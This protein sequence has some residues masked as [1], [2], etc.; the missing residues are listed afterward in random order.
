MVFILI[1]LQFSIN[2]FPF[3]IIIIFFA[4][5]FSRNIFHSVI[6]SEQIEQFLKKQWEKIYMILGDQWKKTG[7]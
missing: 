4:C 6:K 1:Y 3:F 2:I 7:F 5:K